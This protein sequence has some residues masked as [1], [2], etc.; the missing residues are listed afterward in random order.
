MLAVEFRKT[1]T[2][3]V[4]SEGRR[5]VLGV[6]TDCYYISHDGE[7]TRL[8]TQPHNAKKHKMHVNNNLFYNLKWH[9]KIIPTIKGAIVLN[10]C[11][12]CWWEKQ[13][14]TAD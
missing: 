7:I 11:C 6:I 9:I 2:E 5:G 1:W 3:M 4:D 12:F 14:P 10:V 13:R 8:K